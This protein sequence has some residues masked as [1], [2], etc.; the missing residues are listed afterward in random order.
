[1]VRNKLVTAQE[2]EIPLF[3]LIIATL[4]SGRRAA[5]LSIGA[6]ESSFSSGFPRE[7]GGSSRP[8]FWYMSRG[9]CSPRLGQ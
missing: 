1:M 3:S 2:D 6:S 9:R 4:L 7:Y 5:G 8:G